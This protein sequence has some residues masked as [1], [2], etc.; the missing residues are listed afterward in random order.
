MICCYVW[1]H[2]AWYC[3][4]TQS[5]PN[6]SCQRVSK[7]SVCADTL[8]LVFLRHGSVHHNLMGFVIY[9]LSN[10]T[11]DNLFFLEKIFYHNPSVFFWFYCCFWIELS[12][13]P[14]HYQTT[15]NTNLPLCDMPT[16][17]HFWKR[18]Y[19]HLLRDFLWI[20]QWRSQWSYTNFSRIVRLKKPY[21]MGGEE[22]KERHCRYSE[23]TFLFFVICF[24]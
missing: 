20:R 23:C 1:D 22:K 12:Y 21:E 8:C 7:S 16:L 5:G 6:I 3:C 13:I 10:V 9:S 2:V 15:N 24:E 19:W 11:H 17:R 14:S 18:Q 4:M